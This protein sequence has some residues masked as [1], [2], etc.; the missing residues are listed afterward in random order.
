MVLC[1]LYRVVL[2]LAV[3][4]MALVDVHYVN[5]LLVALGYACV[6]VGAFVRGFYLVRGA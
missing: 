4:N 1:I 5:D 2:A 3:L 6:G